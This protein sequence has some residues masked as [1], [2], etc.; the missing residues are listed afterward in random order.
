MIPVI[1]PGGSVVGMRPE[2]DP[3]TGMPVFEVKARISTT[4]P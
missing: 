1:G 4:R 2:M 3:S